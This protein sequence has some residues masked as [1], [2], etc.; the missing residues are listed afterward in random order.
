[1][2]GKVPAVSQVHYQVQV[3]ETFSGVT[4]NEPVES[5]RDA[6]NVE[7]LGEQMD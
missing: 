2:I 3:R 4:P 6:E 7:F 1:M 5:H